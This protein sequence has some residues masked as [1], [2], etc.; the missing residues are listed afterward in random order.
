MNH[1]NAIHE[2]VVEVG[3]TDCDCCSGERGH[4]VLEPDGTDSPSGI[5]IDP[6]Q[7]VEVV[8][9]RDEAYGFSDMRLCRVLLTNEQNSE[10][11]SRRLATDSEP[12]PINS[13]CGK[14]DDDYVVQ[15]VCG[16]QCI[17]C[18][19]CLESGRASSC[20]KCG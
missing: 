17:A 18:S 16:T 20:G 3:S 1:E 4:Y 11:L 2:F 15:C 10:V 5:R 6:A 9:Q 14:G 13:C 7:I 8:E 12:K 19:D